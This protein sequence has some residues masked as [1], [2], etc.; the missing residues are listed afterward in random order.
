MRTILSVLIWAAIPA[1]LWAD[2]GEFSFA[3]S[4]PQPVT[5]GN[6]S[7]ESPAHG[8]GGFVVGSLP[9]W[10]ASGTAGNFNPAASHYSG[11]FPDGVQLG[12]LNPGAQLTQTLSDVLAAGT[13]TLAVDVVER[14]DSSAPN[15]QVQLFAGSTLLGEFDQTDFPT[16]DNNFVSG[17][18]TAVI[19]GSHLELGQP[20][21]IRLLSNSG[22]QF[23]PDNVQLFFEAPPLTPEPGSLALFAV[24]V[25]AFGVYWRRQ[26]RCSA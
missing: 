5:V 25:L 4:A 7:F 2:G 6:F 21:E 11:P 20:L 14:D 16:V 17:S 8:D 19:P 26:R 10:T 22:G 18:V 13:Y 1:V 24:A 9:S 15:Y 3:A 23:N 12:F